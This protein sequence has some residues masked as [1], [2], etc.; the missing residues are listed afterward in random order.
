MTTEQIRAGHRIDTTVNPRRMKLR[1][2]RVRIPEFVYWSGVRILLFYRR[3]RYG[4]PFRKIP[5]T[6]G[7]IAMVDEIDYDEVNKFK[8]CAENTDAPFMP[9]EAEK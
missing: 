8:W 2:V 6:H 5:L 1:E 9:V 3:L 7:K 4:Y